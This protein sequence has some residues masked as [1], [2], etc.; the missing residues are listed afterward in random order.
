MLLVAQGKHTAHARI[1]WRVR[2]SNK[3]GWAYPG[4]LGC[5]TAVGPNRSRVLRT[6]SALT[7]FCFPPL[8]LAP[9]AAALRDLWARHTRSFIGPTFF[10]HAT[11]GPRVYWSKIFS[12][13]KFHDLLLYTVTPLHTVLYG[14]CFDL[15]GGMFIRFVFE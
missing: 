10:G 1:K 8:R 15:F 14:V 3:R 5:L 13:T 2:M 4:W 12:P 7:A 9:T 6:Q 11:E